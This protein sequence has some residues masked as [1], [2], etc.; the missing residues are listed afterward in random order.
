[1]LGAGAAAAAASWA[2]VAIALPVWTAAAALL[3]A[4]ALE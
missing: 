3:A 1:L 2:F 4:Y